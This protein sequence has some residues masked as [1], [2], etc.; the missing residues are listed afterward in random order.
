MARKRRRQKRGNGRAQ[1]ILVSPPLAGWCSS[2]AWSHPGWRSGW[3]CYSFLFPFPFSLSHSCLSPFLLRFHHYSRVWP[4]GTS[5]GLPVH[6]R[7]T[8]SQN[9]LII[10][11]GLSLEATCSVYCTNRVNAFVPHQSQGRLVSAFVSPCRIRLHTCSIS[12]PSPQPPPPAFGFVA[13]LGPRPSRPQQKEKKKEK[14]GNS[15]TPCHLARLCSPLP[16][17][18]KSDHTSYCLLSAHRRARSFLP[19]VAFR[20]RHTNGLPSPWRCW[21]SLALVGPL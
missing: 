9:S 4:L 1:M 11:T 10:A 20:F 15:V 19:P 7:Q 6:I 2:I 17:S 18:E 14:N 13:V 3:I 5:T 12:C 21:P 16:S 8:L